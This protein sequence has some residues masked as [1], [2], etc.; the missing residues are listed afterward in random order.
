MNTI[1]QMGFVK[2]ADYLKEKR[3]AAIAYLGEKWVLS[4]ANKVAKKAKK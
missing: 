3:E 1:R 2:E 4:D